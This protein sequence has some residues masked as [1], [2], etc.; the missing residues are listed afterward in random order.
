MDFRAASIAPLAAAAMR[1]WLTLVVVGWRQRPVLLL[2]RWPL[3]Q[4]LR[5]RFD[6]RF[7][8]YPF[9]HVYFAQDLAGIV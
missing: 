7:T 1:A 4:F 3:G 2:R 9:G 6:L 8:E 5:Q